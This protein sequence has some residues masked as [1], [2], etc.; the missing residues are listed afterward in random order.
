MKASDEILKAADHEFA[1]AIAAVRGLY[2]DGILQKPEG[3]K[4]APD[5]LQYYDANQNRAGTLPDHVGVPA[6]HLQVPSRIA[7]TTC[8]GMAGHR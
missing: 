6:A 7:T 5:L 2:R 8:I 4:F 1:K 3:W